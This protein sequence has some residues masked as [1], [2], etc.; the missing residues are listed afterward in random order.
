MRKSKSTLQE[1]RHEMEDLQKQINLKEQE[2]NIEI[3]A[4]VRK[5]TELDS[6]S[7]IQQKFKLVPIQN[8]P[9]KEI[10]NTQTIAPYSA[11]ITPKSLYDSV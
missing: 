11:D 10:I 7:N 9:Q 4:W 5:Q 3:G 2:L 8:E 1:L 6:L